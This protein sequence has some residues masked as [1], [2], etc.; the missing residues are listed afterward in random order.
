MVRYVTGKRKRAVE[1]DP[2]LITNEPYDHSDIFY[3]SRTHLNKL[4]YDTSVYNDNV[5]G[6]SERRKDFY[7]KM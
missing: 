3:D 6:G 4:G 5:A 7:G 2:S 1:Q